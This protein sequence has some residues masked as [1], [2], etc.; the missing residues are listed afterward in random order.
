MR[1]WETRGLNVGDT[2]AHYDTLSGSRVTEPAPP[3]YLYSPRFG[4]VRQVVSFQQNEQSE[5]ALA[6]F[7]P[8]GTRTQVEPV[9]SASSKQHY[10]ARTER[11]H[12]SLH[13]ASTQQ[14]GGVVSCALGPESF[15][16][17]FQ[18]YEN[19][20]VIRSGKFELTEALQL[21]RSA[22]SAQAWSQTI[23]LQVFIDHQQATESAGVTR[24]DRLYTVDRPPSRPKLRI[25]KLASTPHAAPGET[26]HFT[27]RFDNVG[28][29]LIGNVTI[30]DSLAPRLEFVPG[31]AQCS[32][33]A[34]FSTQPHENGSEIL[35]W[36]IIDPLPSGEGG[37]I[38]F[39]CRVR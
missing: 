15:H 28:N 18:P 2:I 33:P 25:I 20:H 10:Q 35:R 19:F 11:G 24:V 16:N 38:R 39:Q 21:A 8:F 27:I 5:T 9:L 34:N 30:I 6:V 14:W 4:S 3:L 32:L 17:G 36:E 22:E 7:A 37:V 31:S 29:E 12:R 13:A 26:V 23:V 1:D